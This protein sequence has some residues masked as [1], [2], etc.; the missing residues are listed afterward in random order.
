MDTR[1]WKINMIDGKSYLVHSEESD[2]VKFT[3]SLLPKTIPGENMSLFKCA[4]EYI[5]KGIAKFDSVVI[6]G[7]KVSSVEYYV[8]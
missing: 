8:G 4:E 2:L 1:I 5:E 6:L 7:S 3:K